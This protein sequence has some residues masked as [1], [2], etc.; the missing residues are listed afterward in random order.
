MASRPTGAPSGTRSA[1][2]RSGGELRRRSRRARR[3]PPRHR[4]CRRSPLADRA[5][6]GWPRRSIRGVELLRIEGVDHAS[7]TLGAPAWLHTGGQRTYGRQG[8]AAVERACRTG[9]TPTSARAT[10]RAPGRGEPVSRRR[11]RIWAWDRCHVR[12]GWGTCRIRRRSRRMVSVGDRRRRG[13]C[14]N[15]RGSPRSGRRRCRPPARLG[16]ASSSSRRGG[17]SRWARPPQ[18]THVM[19]GSGS[20][21]TRISPPVACLDACGGRGVP[22]AQA[23]RRRAGGTT[24]PTTDRVREAVFNALGSL[25]VVVDARVADLYAGSGALGFEALS[26]GAVHCTFVEPDRGALSAIHDN[27][28]ALG[29]SGRTAW[30]PATSSRCAAR[31]MSTWCSPIRRTG[32]TSGPRLLARPRRHRWSS[33]RRPRAGRGAATVGSSAGS[34]ATAA[35][36]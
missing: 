28:A 35:P 21:I 14:P 11:R 24:R 17:V 32:S 27:M 8:V 16:L 20:S 33:P 1:T 19:I 18:S 2:S 30:S 6:R 23:G 9:S 29:V 7:A 4:R 31:S 34:S 12:S 10:S 13:R 26:R 36:G 25:D 22:W 5:S 15:G 3:A